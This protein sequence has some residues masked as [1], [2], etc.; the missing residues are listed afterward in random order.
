MYT[1]NTQI[2]ASQHTILQLKEVGLLGQ[3]LV[4]STEVGK[5]RNEHGT[6][7]DS[8]KDENIQKGWGLVKKT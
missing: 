3:E 1:L 7:H 4:C 8:T 5:I 6:S 2:L